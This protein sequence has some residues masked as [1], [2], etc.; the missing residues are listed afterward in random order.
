[1]VLTQTPKIHI[2]IPDYQSA[3]GGI[4][5]F[6]RFVVRAI[7]DC[8]P[9]GQI[10][11]L[12]KNDRSF[13]ILP[14]HTSP[15]RFDCTGWWAPSRRTTAYTLQLI[16]YGLRDRPDL[17]FC[18]HVNF[19]PVARWLKWFARIPF[20]AIKLACYQRHSILK[21]LFPG[22]SRIICSSASDWLLSNQLF[23]L[24][25]VSLA[26]NVLRATIRS[27]ERFLRFGARSPRCII[28]LA[29]KGRTSRDSQS[30]FEI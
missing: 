24:W 12:S 1:M 7:A 17:I 22:S 20:V 14:T 15:I 19:S 10:T 18:G 28:F 8:F 29:A 2:W 26:R 23:S 3:T 27:Y 6:S 25:R 16:K 11:V 9:D 30:W 5:I 21:Y 13:P 4:Q